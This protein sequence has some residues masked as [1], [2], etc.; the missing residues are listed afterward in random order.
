MKNVVT[1]AMVDRL[2]CGLASNHRALCCGSGAHD[3]TR[4]GCLRRAVS[5]VYGGASSGRAAKQTVAVCM[6]WP[7]LVKRTD[8]ARG[9]RKWA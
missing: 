4:R 7:K 3:Y 8:W 1:R 6:S 5:A 9:A 2:D